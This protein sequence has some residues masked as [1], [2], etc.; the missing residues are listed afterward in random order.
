MDTGCRDPIWALVAQHAFD[1]DTPLTRGDGPL[2]ALA[3]QDVR[4][5]LSPSESPMGLG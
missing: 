2:R 3:A 1:D 5:P 4:G